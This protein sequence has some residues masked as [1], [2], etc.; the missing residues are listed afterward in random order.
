MASSWKSH[1]VLALSVARPGRWGRQL[2]L[3][4]LIS[5]GARTGHAEGNAEPPLAAGFWKT[6]HHGVVTANGVRLHYVEGGSG[7]PLLLISGWPESWYAWRRVMPALAA[8]GRH[9]IAVDPTGFGDSD[10]PS[11]GYDARSVAAELHGVVSA[12]GL[13]KAGPIDVAGHDIGTWIGYAYASDWPG[14]VRRLA[15]YEAALPGIS[16]PPPA[17]IPSSARNVKTWH[18]AFNRLDDLPEILVQGHEREFLAWIFRNKTFRTWAIG[19]ADLDEYVRVFASPGGVRASFAYY[20]AAF[21]PDGLAD[22]RARAQ[23][24]LTQPVLAMGG[25]HG[26]GDAM[27]ATMRTVAT[28]VRGGTTPGCG[29]FILEECPDTVIRDLEAFFH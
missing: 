10:H 8:S 18:F 2:A 7:A 15:V 27:L 21:S 12:L 5:A 6:F 23:R 28:D 11:S 19:P 26:V 3:A 16:P 17:E 1:C 29:H 13:T 9:V 20:R 14:D 4:L 24:K 25:E 22:N